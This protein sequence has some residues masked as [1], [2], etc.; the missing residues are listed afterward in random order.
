MTTPIYHMCR[1]DEWAEALRTGSYAGSS[2]DKDDGF[3]HFST[4]AQIVASAVKHRAGQDDLVL[5]E[6]AAESLGEN[7]KWEASRGG[8]SFPHLYGALDVSKAARA[9]SLKLGPEGRHL[10]PWGF[11]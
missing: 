2:Q 5:I 6:V 9:A 11:A 10:F 1:A 4:A 8:A 3:I 7:L